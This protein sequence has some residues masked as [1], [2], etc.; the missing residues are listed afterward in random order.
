MLCYHLLGR[1][2]PVIACHPFRYNILDPK[3]V[4]GVEDLKTA[5]GML[6][7]AGGLDAD[8]FRLGHTKV[9]TGPDPPNK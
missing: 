1:F 2:Y 7:E 6:L 5:A 3:K 4:K 8:L 9:C